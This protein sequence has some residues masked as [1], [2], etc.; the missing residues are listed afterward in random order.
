MSSSPVNAATVQ[1]PTTLAGISVTLN[2]S[3]RQPQPVPL[4]AVQQISICS[5]GGGSSPGSGSTADCSITAITVQIPF[6][7]LFP[8][9]INVFAA[10]LV[11]SE[12]GNVSTAFSV[13]PVFDNLH[14]ISLCDGFPPVKV[15]STSGFCGPLVT[16]GDGTL[17]TVDAPAQPDE[18]IVIWAY[19][20]GLTSPAAKTGQ[21]SPSPA[22][23]LSSALPGIPL[24]SP[25]LYLQF[26]FRT[27]AMPSPPFINRFAETPPPTPIFAGLAPG[28]VGVYQINVQIPSSIPPVDACGSTCSHV[29]CTM[30]NTATSNLTIDIGANLSWDGAAIC[31]QPPQ[32]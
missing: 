9:S 14:V 13:S 8:P 4:L 19:G 25:P 23:T 3:G 22:A 17:V 11:I 7:L 24:S 31:V 2:Q 28:Q 29:A 20:L 26:D 10:Q 15:T 6:E 1:L 30:Y 21:A 27:N 16:H 18:E 12:N 5:N 32:P